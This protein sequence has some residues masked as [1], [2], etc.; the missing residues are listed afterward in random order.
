MIRIPGIIEA[1]E[2]EIIVEEEPEKG[3]GEKF[4]DLFR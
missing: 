4:L 1:E 3:P 2:P